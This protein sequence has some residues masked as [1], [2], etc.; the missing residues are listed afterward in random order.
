MKPLEPCPLCVATS[1][2]PLEADT[3]HPYRLCPRCRLIWLD[4]ACRPD[5]AAE[6]AQYDTHENDPSDPRYRAFLSR[7]T[8]LL[9]PYLAPGSQGLDYG[10]GPG[11]TVRIMLGEAG[12]GV[13][14]YDPFYHPDMAALARRYDFITCT[15]VAEHFFD[16]GLE[17]Q[18]LDGLLRPG[19]WLGVMTGFPPEEEGAFARWPYARDPTHVCFYGP[20]TMAFIARR[21]GYTLEIPRRN[22]ALFYKPPDTGPDASA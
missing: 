13:T 16:P 15:E 8:D 9:L 3:S 19:G 22:V 18:R 5:P 1:T 4:P 17:F 12:L 14:D 11:P 21:F 2:R 20:H 6:K 7:L 10:A